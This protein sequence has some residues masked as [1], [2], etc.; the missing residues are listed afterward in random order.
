MPMLRCCLSVMSF[1]VALLLGT[2]AYWCPVRRRILRACGGSGD[3]AEIFGLTLPYPMAMTLL[4]VLALI[5]ASGAIYAF[6]P[7]KSDK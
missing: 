7:A 2:E 4:V 6:C 5:F 3:T 1:G